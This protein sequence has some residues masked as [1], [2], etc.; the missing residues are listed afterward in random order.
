MFRR[1]A[2]ITTTTVEAPAG[3]SPWE[4]REKIAASRDAL[5][6]LALAV[7]P[8]L[9]EAR[10]KIAPAV[11]DARVKLGPV[12]EE[13]RDK[14]GPVVEEA[15]D[16]IGP[17]VEE[18][19]ERIGPVMTDARGKVAP[20]AGS[21]LLASKAQGRKAAI[22]LGLVEEPQPAK[23]H[24]IRNL[25][26]VLGLGGAAAF[27]YKMLTGKDADP[28]WTATRDTAAASHANYG[29]K[30]YESSFT[31]SDSSADLSVPETTSHLAAADAPPLPTDAP[32]DQSDTAP[33]A[34][35]ASEETVESHV[36]T[37]PD[38][39]LEKKDL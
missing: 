12:V 15:R 10:D 31:S 30:P 29:S 8:A 38:Q 6:S 13:A 22:R 39:P 18:A 3:D 9:T 11:E 2:R 36:P 20:L 35:F 33:S 32:D 16:K 1:T 24:K 4:S 7:G 27:A 25:L 37:T 14:I 23:G 21:A 19:R 28:A 26:L 34:P 5:T 17:V